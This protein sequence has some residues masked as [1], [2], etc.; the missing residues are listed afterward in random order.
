MK[1]M[2]SNKIATASIYRAIVVTG[3]SDV[4]ITGTR[5]GN[6]KTIIMKKAALLCFSTEMNVSLL[7]VAQPKTLNNRNLNTKNDTSAT[8]IHQ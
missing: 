7:L 4:K 3:N 2:K 8:R 6:D 5:A 1:Y